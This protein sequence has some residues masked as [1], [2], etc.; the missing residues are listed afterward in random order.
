M[1]APSRHAR[2]HAEYRQPYGELAALAGAVALRLDG[3]PVQ[4]DQAARDGKPD[5]ESA[6]GVGAGSDLREALEQP[7]PDVRRDA[8]AV[9]AHADGDARRLEARKKPDHAAARRVLRRVVEQVR[10]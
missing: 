2:P 4:L 10:Q 7:R 8:H 5:A 6:V 3:A 9:V 1:R